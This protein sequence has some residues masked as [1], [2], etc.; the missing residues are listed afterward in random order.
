[1]SIFIYSCSARRIS[2]EMNLISKEIRRAEHECNV[3]SLYFYYVP[4]YHND[5]IKLIE[6]EQQHMYFK[7]SDWS[8]HNVN[9]YVNYA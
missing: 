9:N 7:R 3:L 4:K 1:M 5:R 6:Q 8:E 2:F